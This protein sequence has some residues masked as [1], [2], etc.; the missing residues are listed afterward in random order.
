[1]I[2]FVVAPDRRVLPD[3]AAKAPG[4]GI[5]LSARGDVLETA[6]NRGAF[7]KAA[8]GSVIVPPD[9]ASVLQAGLRQRI[10]DLVGLA[11]RAGQAVCGF[12]KAHEWLT[13]GRVGLVVQA[14]DGSADE[15]ARFLSGAADGMRV[16]APLTAAQLGAVFGRE[17]GVHA[18]VAHGR[19]A[20]AI[21]IEAE[22]LRGLV[23]AAA[24]APGGR[25]S[26]L[27]AGV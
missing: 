25:E 5:W 27:Q 23:G 3:L 12:Q 22:R 24:P 6:R 20:E 17:H 21:W 16:I 1:M 13:Q 15:R 18:A 26:N 8:R 19:L 10:T 14:A 4:R 11:R 9:L 7:A 2:R